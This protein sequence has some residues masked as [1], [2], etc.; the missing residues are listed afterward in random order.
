MSKKLIDQW[1]DALHFENDR[2]KFMPTQ[3]HSMI[4]QS[5]IRKLESQ[6]VA[7]I[8]R[9]DLHARIHRLDVLKQDLASARQLIDLAYQL[10]ERSIDD[11]EE[12]LDGI[13]AWFEKTKIGRRE[14]QWQNLAF[15]RSS[16]PK[17]D[18]ARRRR[19]VQ[20]FATYSR[21]R[22][23]CGAFYLRIGTLLRIK[24]WACR[25]YKRR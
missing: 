12:V 18:G 3:L 4:L 15:L 25:M 17:A 20:L 2:L 5:Q 9:D 6:P 14:R 19:M 21:R 23:R 8:A 7:G 22:L 16:W 24:M 10:R 1:L 13:H 11:A